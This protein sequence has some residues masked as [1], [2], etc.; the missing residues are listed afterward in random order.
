MNKISRTIN[1]NRYIYIAP[2]FEQ[3]YKAKFFVDLIVRGFDSTAC[4]HLD[5]LCWRV[6]VSTLT[7][8]QK[9]VFGEHCIASVKIE[10]KIKKMS[11]LNKNTEDI[12]QKQCANKP[13]RSVS[14]DCCPLVIWIPL[15]FSIAKDIGF[16]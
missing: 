14:I 3:T 11:L 10:N 4:I 15:T 13:I 8:G 16:F 6:I 5:T 1:L 12:G 7:I 9:I 2:F